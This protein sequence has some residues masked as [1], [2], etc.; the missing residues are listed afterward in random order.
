MRLRFP[1]SIRA[2]TPRVR[3]RAFAATLAVALAALVLGGLGV[4]NPEFLLD[5]TP[6]R[7]LLNHNINFDR[8]ERAIE[9]GQLKALEIG[10]AHV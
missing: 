5:C 6:L 10:R 7:E 9:R 1:Q 3:S 4:R 8:I 2:R